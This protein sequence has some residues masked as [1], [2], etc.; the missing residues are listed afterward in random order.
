M[1]VI[2]IS[3]PAMAL[4]VSIFRFFRFIRSIST[5]LITVIGFSALLTYVFILY[6]PTDGPGEML[7]MGWQAWDVVDPTDSDQFPINDDTAV[8]GSPEEDVEWWTKADVS[9]QIDSSILP[10]DVWSMTGLI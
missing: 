9:N 5:Q 2:S 3:T 4:R 6:Q 10:L 7:R 1:L 8:G